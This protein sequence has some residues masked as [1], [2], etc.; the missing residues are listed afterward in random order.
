MK[1][2]EVVINQAQNLIDQYGN[3]IA[4]LGDADGLHVF[5]FELPNEQENGFPI[6]YLFDSTTDNVE[7]VEGM[8]V[9]EILEPLCD[10]C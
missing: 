2:P 9:F 5:Q 10:K 1:I 4:Y 8:R 3:R 6:V 7:V